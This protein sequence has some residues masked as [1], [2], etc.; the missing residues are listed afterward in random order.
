MSELQRLTAILVDAVN[1]QEPALPIRI[2][3]GI[4]PAVPAGADPR[5][6]ATLPEFLAQER[7]V[8]L[9]VEAARALL[10]RLEA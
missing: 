2:A 5:A 4:V 8:F 6:Y 3:I 10:A 9:S 1:R 7:E